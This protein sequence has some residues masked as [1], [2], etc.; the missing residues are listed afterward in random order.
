MPLVGPVTTTV[1]PAASWQPIC[2]SGGVPRASSFCVGDIVGGGLG[3]TQCAFGVWCC[4][5]LRACCQCGC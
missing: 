4:E 1:M 5:A 2:S 3:A